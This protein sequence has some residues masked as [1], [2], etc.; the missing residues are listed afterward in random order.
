MRE[1]IKARFSLLFITLLQWDC[2]KYMIDSW[3]SYIFLCQI[4]PHGTVPNAWS[5]NCLIWSQI[6]RYI[7]SHWGIIWFEVN[8]VRN[9]HLDLLANR[10]FLQKIEIHNHMIHIISLWA[11][12]ISGKTG[13]VVL[14]LGACKQDFTGLNKKMISSFPFC[15]SNLFSVPMDGGNVALIHFWIFLSVIWTICC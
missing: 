7:L 1:E 9:S 13:R 5:I 11:R 3:L 14:S 4:Y 8:T 12:K 6:L 10:W 2:V 15:Q